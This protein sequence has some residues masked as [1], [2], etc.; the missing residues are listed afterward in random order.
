VTE[1]GGAA[2]REALC[3]AAALALVFAVLA[4]R[5]YRARDPDSRLHAEITAR[6]AREPVSRW[7]APTMPPGWYLSGLFREHPAGIFALPALLARLGYPADQAAYAANALYQALTLVVLQ[8]LA[9]AWADGLEARSL[10]WLVQLLPIAFTYRVRA[11]HEQAVLLAL[12]VALL[13]L[14]RSRTRPAWALLT[15]AG[16]VGLLLVKGLFVLPALVVC[17]LWILARRAAL[18]PGAPGFRWCWAGLAGATAA[19]GVAVLAYEHLYRQATGEPFWSFY[20]GRQL[21]VAAVPQSAE[22]LGQKAYNLVWYLGRILWFPF[23]W[24][25]ALLVALVRG[26]A[27]RGSETAASVRAARA[28]LLFAASVAA[29]YVLAFSLSDR[30]ADRYIFP[31]YFVVGAAGGVVALRT[32]GALRGWCARLDR[33]APALVPAVFVLAF[34]LHFVGGLIG[35]P[36]VKLWAPDR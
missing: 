10:G 12:L 16:L 26:P 13:G 3:W 4:V 27:R 31:A 11:N 28:G 23:P 17:G 14:E 18:G 35:L 7:I 34:A 20:A 9:L 19:M 5:G 21:G 25:V 36:T 1:R 2:G 22:Y 32:I 8:R 30:R 29:V 24:S 15:A 6:L 33:F